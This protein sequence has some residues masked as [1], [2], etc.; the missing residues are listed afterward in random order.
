MQGLHNCGRSCSCE[1]TSKLI[2]TGSSLSEYGRKLIS[3][4]LLCHQAICNTK[5]YCFAEPSHLL[6]RILELH[7]YR[8][9]IQKGKSQG[10]KCHLLMCPMQ[11]SFSRQSSWYIWDTSILGIHSFSFPSVVLAQSE[12]QCRGSSAS[13]C[14][15]L[16]VQFSI[17]SH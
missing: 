5:H 3:V 13:H 14:A 17:L 2:A 1:L 12:L 11:I 16:Q 6:L 4:I 8:N 9:G 10:A 15:E 7:N